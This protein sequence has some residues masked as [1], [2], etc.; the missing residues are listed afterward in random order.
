MRLD[1]TNF[2]NLGSKDFRILTAIEVGMKNHEYVPVPLIISIANLPSCGIRRIITNLHKLKLVAHWNKQYDGYK[3]TYLGLDYLALR[4]FSLGGIIESVG[5][6]IGVGKEADVHIAK[7]SKGELVVIKFHRLGRKSF[8]TIKLNR[9]YLGKRSY[10]SWMYL[11]QIAAKKEYSYLLSMYEKD[12]PVPKPIEINR[13]AIVMQYI[14]GVPLSQV[15]VLKT[16][17]NTLETLFKLIIDMAEIGIIHGDFNEFN[18][19]VD[20]GNDKLYLI[21]FPQVIPIYHQN[22]AT[23]FNRDVNCIVELFNRKFKVIACDYPKFE[24]VVSDELIH[25]IRSAQPHLKINNGDEIALQNFFQHNSSYVTSENDSDSSLYSPND[26]KESDIHESGSD[27]YKNGEGYQTILKN[28]TDSDN[29]IDDDDATEVTSDSESAD[30]YHIKK[31]NP[32]QIWRPY[33]SRNRE[34]NIQEN[35]RNKLRN[36]SKSEQRKNCRQNK[37]K[38]NFEH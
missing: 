26:E 6:R 4:T 9:D 7:E 28:D 21:D 27:E 34:K 38:Y 12:F 33:I 20:E 24:D 23:Y 30:N 15:R 19:I 16:P 8:R 10:A 1:A 22:A 11:A 17:R 37:I 36:K 31:S 2:A 13:H 32:I 3:L 14:D 25:S 29:I 35:V 5:R 18:L